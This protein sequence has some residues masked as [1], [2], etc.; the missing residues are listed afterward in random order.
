MRQPK[1]SADS[2]ILLEAGANQLPDGISD[3]H[4][5]KADDNVSKNRLA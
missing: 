2:E 3:S 1:R 4:R 5:Q